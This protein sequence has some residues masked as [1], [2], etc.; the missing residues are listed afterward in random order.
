MRTAPAEKVLAYQLAVSIP[1]L[2]LG[3]LLMGER[4][5]AMPSAWSLGWL[6]YQTFWVVSLTFAVWF[7][8][9]QRYSASRLS[10][11]TFLTPIVR[12]R[13]RPFRARGTHFLGLRG[14]GGAGD[15]RSG[16]GEPA[17]LTGSA[18]TGFREGVYRAFSD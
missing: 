9:V 11:F 17:E 2:A 10:A 15:G 18:E 14:G 5:T 8:M 7:A 3:V 1:M 6:A 12:G 16:A 4:M 13:V